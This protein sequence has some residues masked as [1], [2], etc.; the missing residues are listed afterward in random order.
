[1]ARLIK[2]FETLLGVLRGSTIEAGHNLRQ[3]AREFDSRL[4][5]L[6]IKEVPP[7]PTT[8]IST[9]AS[10]RPKTIQL[11]KIALPQFHGNVMEWTQFWEQFKQA[12]HDNPDVTNPN[13]LAYLRYAIRDP[14]TRNLLYCGSETDGYYDKIVAVLHSRFDQ[15]H[16]IYTVH[17]RTLADLQLAKSTKADLTSL[18][19]TIYKAV[20][21]LRR[22]GQFETAP[23]ATSLA[24]AALPKNIK[25]DWEEKMEMTK[26]VPDVEELIDFIRRQWLPPSP[27]HLL[28][29]SR[30]SQSPTKEGIVSSRGQRQ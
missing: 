12:V 3:A 4:T 6:T 1:M 2:T 9:P 7:T 17:C 15:G 22:T 25:E 10:T 30:K 20:S 16:V 28:R 24:M 11:P 13:K 8:I 21:G 29:R 18:A 14:E 19:D 23:F 26:K 27:P 5:D